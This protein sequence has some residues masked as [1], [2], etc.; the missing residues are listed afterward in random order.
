MSL[1]ASCESASLLVAHVDPIDRFSFPQ[2]VGNA[3]ERVADHTVDAFDACLLQRFDQ[4]LGRGLAHNC[5]PWW[6]KVSRRGGS[7]REGDRGDP[8]GEAKA[9]PLRRDGGS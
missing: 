1:R 9:G 3:V 8:L 5:S 4:I 2:R 6:A 7:P